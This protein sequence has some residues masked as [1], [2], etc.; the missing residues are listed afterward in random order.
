MLTCLAHVG[1]IPPGKGPT[2]CQLLNNYVSKL[3]GWELCGS[4]CGFGS[5]CS[6]EFK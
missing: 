5:F 4:G 1:K 2:V 3:L 6:D